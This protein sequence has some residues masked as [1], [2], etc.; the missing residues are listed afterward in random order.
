M[1]FSAKKQK[2]PK[3]VTT[4]RAT[5]LDMGIRERRGKNEIL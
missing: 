4:E 2:Q 3:D 5:S 1:L